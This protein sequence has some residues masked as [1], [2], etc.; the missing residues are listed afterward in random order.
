MKTLLAQLR[1]RNSHPQTQNSYITH[2][3]TGCTDYIT[4][5]GSHTLKKDEFVCVDCTGSL[6]IA[7][8]SSLTIEGVVR[9]DGQE[10][11]LEPVKNAWGA[12]TGRYKVTATKDET[13]NIYLPPRSIYFEMSQNN[14]D[15]EYNE[16]TKKNG[17]S[18]YNGIAVLSLR[19]SRG[20]TL[21]S[22]V[23]IFNNDEEFGYNIDTESMIVFNP[24]NA[25]V[26]FHYDEEEIYIDTQPDFALN[27]DGSNQTIGQWIVI[28]YNA[29]N[30][31]IEFDIEETTNLDDLTGDYKY[32]VTCDIDSVNSVPDNFPDNDVKLTR[33]TI[34]SEDTE[35]YSFMTGGKL[36]AGVIAAIVIAVVVVVALIVVLIVCY[37]CK[38]CCFKKDK[39]SSSSSS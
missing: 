11:Y 16:L 13:V 18:R 38:C 27:D 2:D 28:Q 15:S 24:N 31:P 33:N 7:L 20:V 17:T 29:Y 12:S 39:S 1:A 22:K 32:T 5:S 14:V 23:E 34:F 21:T 19:E 9:E 35:Q 26:T 3:L 6:F 36:S 25:S 30:S 4:E 8:G 10:K 37:C